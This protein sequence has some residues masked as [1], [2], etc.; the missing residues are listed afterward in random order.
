MAKSTN[1]ARD[2][3]RK[4]SAIGK[5]VTDA[6]QKLKNPNMFG[7]GP[8]TDPQGKIISLNIKAFGHIAKFFEE[9]DIQTRLIE[10]CRKNNLD[11]SGFDE[12]DME[13]TIKKKVESKLPEPPLHIFLMKAYPLQSYLST[14]IRLVFSDCVCT[15]SYHIIF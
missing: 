7:G 1:K 11:Y 3:D 4:F 15:I 2:V 9:D 5:N 10:A 8:I 13:D 12:E 6:W 14:V